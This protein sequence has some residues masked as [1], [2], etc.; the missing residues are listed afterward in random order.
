MK[1][2]FAFSARTGG[3]HRGAAAAKVGAMVAQK[4]DADATGRTASSEEK[5]EAEILWKRSLN[6]Y[7]DLY[8][9]MSPRRRSIAMAAENCTRRGA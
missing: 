3:R 8:S 5:S 6:R 9:I 4:S 2:A 7:D 1:F